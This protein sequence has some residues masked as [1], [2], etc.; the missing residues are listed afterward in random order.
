[1]SRTK[2]ST[3]HS[4][5]LTAGAAVWCAQMAEQPA[6]LVDLGARA[7]AS[8]AA[9]KLGARRK[10]RLEVPFGLLIAGWPS[11]PGD[12]VEAPHWL[13]LSELVDLTCVDHQRPSESLRL[14]RA[15]AHPPANHL[16]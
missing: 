6:G 1:M 13:P 11:D 10:P 16:R 3:R 4:R 14:Q 8:A 9:G 12:L 15:S 7:W 5:A 2:H